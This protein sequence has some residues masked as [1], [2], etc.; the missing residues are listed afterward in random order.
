MYPA[1][2]K[3]SEIRAA[4]AVITKRGDS[5]PTLRIEETDR[6]NL[7][8]IVSK[9]RTAGGHVIAIAPVASSQQVMVPLR[10]IGVVV[11]TTTNEWSGPMDELA[12]ALRIAVA[13]R[14]G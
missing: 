14:S 5:C 7:A 6:A 8:A 9:E 12:D 2:A 4:L 1:E 11:G 13:L 3:Q 10:G